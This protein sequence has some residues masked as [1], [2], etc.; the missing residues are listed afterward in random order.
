MKPLI[1]HCSFHSLCAA[2]SLATASVALGQG[3]VSPLVGI[4]VADQGYRS[5]E[6]LFRS[7]GVYQI[8]TK[9]YDSSFSLGSTY[10][11]RY[12]IDGQSLTL[13][14]YH[15]LNSPVPDSSQFEVVGDTL[16]LTGF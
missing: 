6:L 11:G 2:V 9:L 10:R 13:T 3:G 15:Y 1:Q 8:D 16:V 14:S 4:W 5:V 7:D 12:V